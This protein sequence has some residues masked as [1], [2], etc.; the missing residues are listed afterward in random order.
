MYPLQHTATHATHCNT[1]THP[2]NRRFFSTIP[3]TSMTSSRRKRCNTLYHTATHCNTLQYSATH[4]HIRRTDFP[5]QGYAP[6]RWRA[7]CVHTRQHCNTLQHAAT[8][9]NTFTH[10]K[11][12]HSFSLIPRASM[13]SNVHIHAATHCNS[14]H[15]TAARSHTRQTDFPAKDTSSSM[16]SNVR[17]HTATH[18]NTLQHT[19]TH[20]IA[21]QLVYTTD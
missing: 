15:H 13:T 10:S 14:L 2:K 4:I 16:T 9:C 7:T 11:D 19:A 1:R 8:H 3:R 6:S 18:Y 12:R 20:C 5:F 21:L 17:V